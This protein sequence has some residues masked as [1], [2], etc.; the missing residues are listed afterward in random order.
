MSDVVLK[1][2]MSEKAYEMSQ[3]GVFVFVVDGGLN[4]HEIAKAV[5]E[6]YDVTVETVRIVIQNG[7]AKRLY[8]NRRFTEGMR[9]D[10]KKAYV[11]LKKGDS[12][13]IFAAVE[14]AEEAEK[15]ATDKADKKAAKPAKKSKKEEKK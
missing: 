3:K 14:E 9:S 5:A 11:T 6:T 2:R 13:P 7:K 1:P 10:M 4:K 8:R 12:I 15:K